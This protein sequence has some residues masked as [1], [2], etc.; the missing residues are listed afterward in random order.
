MAVE[1][2]TRV[3]TVLAKAQVFLR[4]PAGVRYPPEL[5][6]DG[7]RDAL[8]D[9]A[10]AGGFLRKD[11]LV[12]TVGVESLELFAEPVRVE[13]VT[14]DGRTIRPLDAAQAEIEWGDKWRT[15]TAPRPTGYVDE[16]NRLRL[17]PRPEQ[18]G[19]V[20]TF[21]P[22]TNVTEQSFRGMRAVDQWGALNGTAYVLFRPGDGQVTNATSAARNVLV[23]YS[24]LPLSVDLEA[25]FPL[26]FERALKW[27]AI[28]LALAGA[29]RPA[30]RAI[31][32]EAAM[33]IYR[34]EKRKLVER[35]RGAVGG[36][37][38]VS[39]DAELS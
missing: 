4:D 33:G 27:Y 26:R 18:A 21:G 14:Y 7:I 20:L 2:Y 36:D 9:L 5:M 16:G 25:R 1:R 39:L 15:K 29:T 8:D 23:D 22:T 32:P 34:T 38:R 35:A 11:L 24:Y 17:V 28:A 13:N 10:E 19:E 37:F 12:P 6:I 31:G 30:R 3:Q